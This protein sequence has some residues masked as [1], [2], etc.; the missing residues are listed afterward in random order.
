MLWEV[1]IQ[2]KGADP[3]RDRVCEEY[4]LL[5]HA[6]HGGTINTSSGLVMLPPGKEV[7]RGT[8]RG[9]F[10]QGDLSREQVEQLT[11]E[12]LVDALTE[13]GQIR[14]T[15]EEGMIPC[16]GPATVLFKPGVMDPAALSVLG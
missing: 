14:G 3:E 9:Y 10:L 1:E 13:T 2:P 11:Q 6:G 4:D 15:D 8:A 5:T 7:I 12:L 16:G